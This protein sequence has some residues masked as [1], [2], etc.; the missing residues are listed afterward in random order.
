MD[1]SKLNDS[2]LS[3]LA[4]FQ[5]L[6]TVVRSVIVDEL[7]AL[8]LSPALEFVPEFDDFQLF[9]RETRRKRAIIFGESE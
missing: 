5:A 9:V 8:S 6:P 4:Y 3:V 2:D 1:V 7:R